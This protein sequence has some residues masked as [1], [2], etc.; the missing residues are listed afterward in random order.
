MADKLL[1]QQLY[2]TGWRQ[3]TLLPVL[4]WSVIYNANDPLTKIAKSAKRQANDRN[5]PKVEVTSAEITFPL[6][7]IASGITSNNDY[8]VIISQDCDIA[9]DPNSI[10]TIFAMR[11]FLTENKQILRPAAGNSTQYFLLD[12]ERGLVAD[13]T[14]IVPIEKPVL[15]N[16]T[17]KTG[18]PNEETKR[19]FAR[20]VAHCFNRPAFPDEVVKAVIKPILDN[21]RFMQ[22][23]E[24]S[25]LE[26]LEMVKELRVAPLIGDPPYK[27][28]LLFMVSEGGLPD[29]GLALAH[30]VGH[31]Y[32]WFD[33]AEARLVAWD[34]SHLY[35][36]SAGD[37]MDT[38]QIYLDHYTYNGETIRGLVPPF[39]PV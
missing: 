34:T 11:A 7:D 12:K 38:Q 4:P 32:E 24:D 23:N 17:P 39:Y 18:V 20:W 15:T 6:Y 35:E 1:G 36:V 14:I 25:Q 8:L 27:V 33:P 16:F 10:R 26:V 37:Y 22:E 21:L 5:R 13:S 9:K 2:A 31:M 19:L 3:G 29:D 28:R 30:F